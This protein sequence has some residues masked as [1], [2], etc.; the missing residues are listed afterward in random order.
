MNL[1]CDHKSAKVDCWL[2][3]CSGHFASCHRY[4]KI[5]KEKNVTKLKSYID[6]YL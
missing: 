1:C 6:F 4:A 5:I 2:T 3:A